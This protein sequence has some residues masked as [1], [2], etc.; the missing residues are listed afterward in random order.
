MGDEG[1]ATRKDY[2]NL[3]V[4][5]AI[6]LAGILIGAGLMF[7]LRGNSAPAG[8]S[9]Q[10]PAQAVNVKDVKTAGEPYVGN[11]NAPLTMAY[12]FD[13]Q[14][15]FCKQ[16]DTA[17][18][19]TL[20][21]KYA[22]TGKLKII[23]KDFAFLGKDS[24]TGA[25]YERAVWKLYPDK[26]LEW[27][28]AM[29]KAQDEEGDQGFGNAASIDTLIKTLP[30][31]DGAKVKADIAANKAKYDADIAADQEEGASFG[32]QGTPGFIIGN[33]GIDGAQPL[34]NF[35]AAIDPQLK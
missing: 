22:A 26:F 27:H 32:I 29:F 30:G 1:T 4:P 34:A 25:E 17:V 5:G 35:I 33:R 18:L 7:G 8:G 13:Y 24:I 9:A 20:I 23:F 10:A 11:E 16:F 12:W 2:S 6:V 3:Y 15:P 14:C 28:E 19:P 31:I 21:E